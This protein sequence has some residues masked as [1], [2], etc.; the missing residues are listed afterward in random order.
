MVRVRM[1]SPRRTRT[2]V[3]AGSESP[4]AGSLSPPAGSRA[5]TSHQA[6]VGLVASGKWDG[7]IGHG[8]IGDP[9]L[10]PAQDPVRGVAFTVATSPRAH[11]G[12]V[13]TVIGLGQPEASDR[14]SGGHRRQPLKLLLLRAVFPDREHGQ[15]SLD[16]DQ[17]TDAR[18]GGFQLQASQAVVH[19]RHACASI[20]LQVHPEQAEPAELSGEIADAG[21]VTGLEPFGD[22]RVDRGRAEL[23]DGG[24]HGLLVG[25]EHVVDAGQVQRVGLDPGPR[26]C[27]VHAQI[28]PRLPANQP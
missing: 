20:A 23:P 3:P 26:R 14:P 2:I 21:Q 27:C 13:G 4:P 24:P 9:H 7:H 6:R 1:V 16:A 8:A 17:R 15:G 11:V 5:R 12:R 25:A 22:V 19:R 28:V 10:R 18:V